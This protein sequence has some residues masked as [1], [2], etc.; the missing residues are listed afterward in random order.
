MAARRMLLERKTEEAVDFHLTLRV[1]ELHVLEIEIV[2]GIVR[3][4]QTTRLVEED[5]GKR[6]SKDRRC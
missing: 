3:V 6:R 4:Y 5:R 1:N 2:G